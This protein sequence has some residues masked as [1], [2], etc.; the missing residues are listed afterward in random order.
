M[1]GER[2]K[3]VEALFEAAEQRSADQRTE[4]LRQACP[5]DP[6]LCA[7]VESL[8]KA[9][10]SR[11]P[12]LDGSPL[13]S[14]AE[15][16]PA[17][18]PGD[19]LGNFE[20]LAMIGR[21]GMG[22]VY[23]ARDVRLKRDVA[24]KTLPSG[25]ATDRDR[26]TRFEREA[27]S[28]SALNHPNI[29][30]VHDVG[31]EG[32]V[33]FIVSE[34]VDGE[35]LAQIIQ[36]APIPLRKL[37]EVSTQI[38]DG[39]AAAHAAGVIHRDLKPG[40]IMLTNDGR[41]KILDFGLAR[42][43]Q[44]RGVD[45]TTMEA[46]HPGVI[47]GTPG[48]MSPEQVRGEPTDARSDIFSL[49][50]ILYEMASGKRAFP[51]TSSVEVMNSI[52]KD[53]P[54]ELPPSS[55][56][57]LD[58]IVRRCI[59]KQPSR[60]FQS[61]ADLGFALR[62]LSP[63]P[64]RERWSKRTLWLR[65]AAV[66][67]LCAISGAVYWLG[68]RLRRPPLP[69]EYTL[70]RLTNNTGRNSSAAISPD[71]KL[72]AFSSNRDNLEKLGDIW[73]QQIDGGGLIRITEGG[74]STDPAFSPD[75]TQIVFH[76]ARQGGIYIAPALG[77]EARQLASEGRDP[78]FSPDG[79]W[80]KYRTGSRTAFSTGDWART[81]LF[82]R[83]VSS[84]TSTQVGTGCA[85]F[86]S[87][88]SPDSSRI[89]FLAACGG[90]AWKP[91]VYNLGTRDLKPSNDL[92]LPNGMI[93]Q[94]VANPSRLLI[95][96]WVG[97]ANVLTAVPVSADGTK[98]TGA[99]Q[100]LASLTDNIAQ[101]SAALDG[102]MVLSVMSARDHIWGL[103]IDEKGQAAGE[104]K[105]LTYGP[106]GERYAFLSRDGGK[107]A[108][109][110]SPVDHPRVFYKDL[111]T[112]REKEVSAAE[113][114]YPALALNPDGTG[115][116]CWRIPSTSSRDSVIEYLPVNGGLPKKIWD[117][118]GGG[119]SPWDQS[120]D[121]KTLLINAMDDVSKP[122]RGT[123]ELVDLDSLATTMYLEDTELDLWQA[124][125][126]HDGRWVAF[127]ATTSDTKLSRI[128]IAPFRMGLVPRSEWIP[129]PHG[130][131]DDKPRFSADD[132]LVYFLSGQPNTP[133]RVWA[134]RLRSDMRPDGK[135]FAIFPPDDKSVWAINSG[136]IAVGP[137]L[138]VFN[139]TESNSNIWLLE[140]AKGGA[141]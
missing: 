1:P 75:G 127:N 106:A 96:E 17:L 118:P 38:C 134:Q 5:D 110:S 93:Q 105:Q 42:Q 99:R 11:D 33:S 130:D 44:S 43:D 120:T 61:A 57:E 124:H 34:L 41:V 40:N 66:L 81:K 136:E 56:P 10:E 63:S 59:E 20:I 58:R 126:S 8:L 2:W 53:E 97:D 24:I 123:V 37:I 32:G 73:V 115:I 98:V 19:K 128:Y 16:P 67:A 52:L 7:E 55:P 70:R 72:M 122:W 140:P 35:T 46:S 86:W 104:P 91:W 49:G 139:K 102:R 64:Q 125:F 116:F 3:Q 62:T 129:I 78:W 109:L 111:A 135:P 112:A 71:G 68:V 13:S 92:R 14:L 82:V 65:S 22:E 30:S 90:D 12:L 107:M 84:G 60:R 77:G 15:R 89:L 83:S 121:G 45:S 88:W 114:T 76:S 27:R 103:P 54:P 132:K 28:A 25:F 26:I 48:Y 141:K 95:R 108:F 94:W 80:L 47:M 87:V 50:V 101:T 100:I 138:I 119:A 31:T 69:P 6:E 29:V 9:A 36:R 117:K 137:R 4:F 39:L 51:G 113:G 131:W 79:Q 133:Y 18:K 85:V 23:R 74:D 21:G